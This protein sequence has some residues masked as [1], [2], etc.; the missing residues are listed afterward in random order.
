MSIS[1]EKFSAFNIE[2]KSSLS[3]ISKT[4][5]A[6]NKEMSL[7]LKQQAYMRSNP[8]NNGADELIPV[9]A[10]DIDLIAIALNEVNEKAADLLAVKAGTMTVDELLV[11]YPAINLIEYS[12]ELL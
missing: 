5:S 12:A 3:S 4:V 2:R 11:K 1:I 7:A 8:D 6:L 10:G 9:V